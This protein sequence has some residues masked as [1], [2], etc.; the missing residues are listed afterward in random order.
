[1]LERAGFRNVR[2]WRDAAGD[3]GVYYGEGA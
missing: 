1:M 3:F 2:C